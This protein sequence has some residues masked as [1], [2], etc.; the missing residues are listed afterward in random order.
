MF[1]SASYAFVNVFLPVYP[2]GIDFRPMTTHQKVTGI[3]ADLLRNKHASPY[4]KAWRSEVNM[5]C[6]TQ[7]MVRLWVAEEARLGI[8]RPNGVLRNPWQPLQSHH[9][10]SGC[11]GRHPE[12]IERSGV[13]RAFGNVDDV[14]IGIP[15][16][17]EEPPPVCNIMT[18][19]PSAERQETVSAH[20]PILHTLPAY[21]QGASVGQRCA[22][23]KKK[24][25][26]TRD[27]SIPKVVHQMD[28]RG[29]IAAVLR[30]AG[31]VESARNGLGPSDLKTAY[32]ATSYLNFREGETWQEV[33]Q[34]YIDCGNA[35]S[36]RE[37]IIP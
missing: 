8:S 2:I 16:N 25:T 26:P 24:K 33:R 32:M 18:A 21:Q 4:A 15:R 30:M 35:C 37:D 34:D 20:P 19:I 29:K 11:R 28:L 6:I 1:T 17:D 9:H 14:T 7:L 36:G 27:A 3:V 22:V 31:V 12:P 10:G 5:L 23:A 13:G